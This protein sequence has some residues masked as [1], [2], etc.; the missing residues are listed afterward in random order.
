MVESDPSGGVRRLVRPLLA[1]V[2]HELRQAVF[3][4]IP[5]FLNAAGEVDWGMPHV[6]VH[7]VNLIPDDVVR[8]EPVGTPGPLAYGKVL[9]ALLTSR[10]AH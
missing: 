1:N 8:A 4:Q 10:I 3:L 2:A 7:L 6:L 9:A 5:A